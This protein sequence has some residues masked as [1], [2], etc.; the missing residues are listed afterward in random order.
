M[1]SKPQSGQRI[2][3]CGYCQ[4]ELSNMKPKQ[5]CIAC[6]R[7][8]Y[9]GA[10]CQKLDWKFV[11]KLQCKKIAKLSENEWN[12]YKNSNKFKAVNVCKQYIPSNTSYYAKTLYLFYFN[13]IYDSKI[14]A[15]LDIPDYITSIICQYVI[16]PTLKPINQTGSEE[17][18]FEYRVKSS[19]KD[20]LNKLGPPTAVYDTGDP[21]WKYQHADGRIV[22][23]WRLAKQFDVGYW[24]GFGDASLFVELDFAIGTYG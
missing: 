1:T 24:T 13:A 3:Q 12:N 6:K 21:H 2:V 10:K 8:Y 14:I 11:H 19:Y 5:R 18:K 23:I 9:C 4:L 22:C 17:M 7:I 15:I 20:I 16:P